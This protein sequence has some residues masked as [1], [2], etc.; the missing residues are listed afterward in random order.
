VLCARLRLI[1]QKVLIVSN[2]EPKAE[3]AL[4]DLIRDLA[5]AKQAREKNF[6]AII[7]FVRFREANGPAKDMME[8]IR[9][10]NKLCKLLTDY[11][12]KSEVIAMIKFVRD[13]KMKMSA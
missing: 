5:H 4:A 10:D 1:E 11:E 7:R 2:A 12:A 6:A 9:R 3:L 13:L 8:Q